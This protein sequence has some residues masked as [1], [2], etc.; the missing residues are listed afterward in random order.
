[1]CRPHQMSMGKPVRV[2]VSPS[3]APRSPSSPGGAFTSRSRWYEITKNIIVSLPLDPVW[4]YTPPVLLLTW[5]VPN[6]GIRYVLIAA[7]VWG[8]KTSQCCSRVSQLKQIKRISALT[9]MDINAVVGFG[10]N[11]WSF[12]ICY[13][14]L[15]CVWWKYRSAGTSPACYGKAF[16]HNSRSAE[17]TGAVKFQSKGESSFS[18]AGG[19][20]S[21]FPKSQLLFHKRRWR[22]EQGWMTAT[23]ICLGSGFG[24][25]SAAGFKRFETW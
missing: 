20:L 10:L 15:L 6:W 18:S 24:C 9:Q 11:Y 16:N 4:K 5:L 17:H 14:S 21:F 25:V 22:R 8:I 2:K 7:Q 19:P 3:E 12:K 13:L 1:M 23:D